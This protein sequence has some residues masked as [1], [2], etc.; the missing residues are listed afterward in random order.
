MNWRYLIPPVAQTAELEM[1]HART[2]PGFLSFFHLLLLFDA[3]LWLSGSA[4]LN[5]GC[6]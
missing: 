5:A 3:P 1:G 4:G 2:P 6:S